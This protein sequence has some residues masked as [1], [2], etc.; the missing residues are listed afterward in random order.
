MT[1]LAPRILVAEDNHVLSAVLQLNLERAGFDVTVAADGALAVEQLRTSNFD[2]LICD[3]QMPQLDGREVCRVAR[4]DLGLER[5]EILICTAKGLEVSLDELQSRFQ[6]SAMI[7]KPFSM[8]EVIEL[9]RK[10]LERRLS[11]AGTG[12]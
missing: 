10:A 8:R 5:L 3:L 12:G 6:V 4:E 1:D 2:L 7:F 11:A 9:I